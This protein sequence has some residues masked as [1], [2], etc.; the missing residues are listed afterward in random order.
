MAFW[1]GEKLAR[2]LPGL[3]TGFTDKNLDC[4][5]Y[6]LSVG[7]QVFA[8]SDK[9]ASNGPSTPL[10]SVLGQ[11]P[12]NMLRIRPGQFAFLMTL[13]S[14]RVPEDALALISMR[15][16]YK[17]KGLINV[18]GFH[19]DPGWQG[20]LLFS[21]YNAGPAE[22]IVERG[23][24]MFLI[25]Y[26]DLDRTS[27]K[28]YNGTSKG[29]VDIKA[30]LLAN[31][32]EQVFSPLMLQRQ[33][34]EIE[35]SREAAQRTIQMQLVNLDTSTKNQIAKVVA[36]TDSKLAELEKTATSTATKVSIVTF[37]AVTVIGLLVS[38]LSYLAAI[39]PGWFGVTLAK[40][41]EGAG[42]E[43]RQKQSESSLDDAA[44]GKKTVDAMGA[45]GAEPAKV[46]RAAHAGSAPTN[47]K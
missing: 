26:A 7:D 33:M 28:L 42:Y 38:V 30:S 25:V 11:P 5:S 3:I 10:V 24:A 39:A 41:L 20:K 13:E 19:V 1:S 17:F 46:D 2:H 34:K 22:V 44:K 27:T 15:A 14:V 31:M 18:S 16:G 9:I 40:T 43:V 35:E 6:R 21:V 29:Q 47:G 4:A 36:D 37:T 32:T 12:A 45:V 23:E 8:T